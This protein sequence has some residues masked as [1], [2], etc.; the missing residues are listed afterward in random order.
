MIKVLKIFHD[1]TDIFLTKLLFPIH[2]HGWLCENG[3]NYESGGMNYERKWS[4]ESS[5]Q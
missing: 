1:L 4:Y 2:S 5:C 3:T